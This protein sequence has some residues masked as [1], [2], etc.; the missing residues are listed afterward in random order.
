MPALINNVSYQY[1]N[2]SIE[3]SV[4]GSSFGVVGAGADSLTYSVSFD[5]EVMRGGSRLPVART[6]GEAEFEGSITFNRHW[7]DYLVAQCAEQGVGIGNLEMTIGVS[8]AHSTDVP[9]RTDTLTG[10]RFGGFDHSNDAGP[11]VLQVECELDIMN[12][13]YDGVDVFGNRQ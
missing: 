5:R 8:Y 7:F 10:V 13:Y 4:P 3:I 12:I 6:D 11:D 2:I 1:S 9:V